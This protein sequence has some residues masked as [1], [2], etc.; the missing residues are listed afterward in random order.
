MYFLTH[1]MLI[2]VG[3]FAGFF[4][5]TTEM[6]DDIELQ[7][8]QYTRICLDQG[9]SAQKTHRFVHCTPRKVF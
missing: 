2:I 1:A 6:N 3:I 8:N 4:V 5:D 9:L 7:I